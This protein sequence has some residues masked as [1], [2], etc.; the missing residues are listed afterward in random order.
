MPDGLRL[1]L[2]T[3]TVLPFRRPG[4]LDRLARG[5]GR[6][7]AP[8]LGIL[9]AL[10]AGTAAYLVRVL[11]GGDLLAAV[12][13]LAIL[14]ALT[15]GMHLEGLA[16][17]ADG[18]A[19]GHDPTTAAPLGPR[20]TVALVLLLLLQAAA[21]ARGYVDHRGTACLVLAVATGW[22][23]AAWAGGGPAATTGSRAPG[24]GTSGQRALLRWTAGLA[25]VAAAY[26]AVDPH[27]ESVGLELL[28]TTAAL[29]VGL[30]TGRLLLLHAVRPGDGMK[31]DQLGALVEVSTAAALLVLA[32]G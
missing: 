29:A 15:R 28:R 18:P 14:A 17:L 27:G 11:G 9:L 21:L 24:A 13:A 2:T 20:G 32:L 25:L 6:A 5:R 7:L 31:G 12:V 8:L 16:R 26:A 1:A 30:G 19:K 4:P 3:L 23:A 22:L 10:V